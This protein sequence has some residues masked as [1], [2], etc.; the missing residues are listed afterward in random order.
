MLGRVTP[1]KYFFKDGLT[2]QVIK[3][4]AFLP[5]TK[6]EIVSSSNGLTIVVGSNTLLLSFWVKK[7]SSF[8]CFAGFNIFIYFHLDQVSACLLYK[9]FTGKRLS[10]NESKARESKVD[11]DSV[12]FSK[13][14]QRFLGK[15]ITLSHTDFPHR[16]FTLK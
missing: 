6:A 5:F 11:W 13:S 15:I 9:R 3:L 10:D 8:F 16:K 1:N 12:T 7:L 2:L 4:C 14:L